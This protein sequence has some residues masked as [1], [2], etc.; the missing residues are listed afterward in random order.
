MFAAEAT[1]NTIDML[2]YVNGE[3]PTCK[4]GNDLYLAWQA[5]NALVR[6]ILVTN[7]TEDVAIQMS[8]SQVVHGTGN[9]WVK[10]ALPVPLPVETCTCATGTGFSAG[11]IFYG[12]GIPVP[13][14]ATGNL[15]VC[16]T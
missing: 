14:P 5:A 11:Q 1:L 12:T 10:L 15:W 6:S 2:S 16:S 8:H 4:I 9:L 7:M 3:I 13:I